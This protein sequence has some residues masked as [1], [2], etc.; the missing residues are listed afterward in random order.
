ML[1]DIKIVFN[2]Y[3]T[4]ENAKSSWDKRKQRVNYDNVFIIFDDIA[5]VEYSDLLAFNSISCKGKVILTAKKYENLQNT[6]QIIRY[7][8]TEKMN[9]YLL[10]KNIWTGKNVADK[11][12]NFVKWLNTSK[13]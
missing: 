1:E 13:I 5:D 3:D 4:N 11:N 9:A 6:V 12:F 10:D 2:H 8:K 7:K